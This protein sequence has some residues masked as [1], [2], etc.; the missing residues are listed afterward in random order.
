MKEAQVFEGWFCRRGEEVVGPL[1]RQ[2]LRDLAATGE[3]HPRDTLWQ[4][5]SPHGDLL[6]PVRAASVLRE[7]RLVVLVVGGSRGPAD[8]VRTLVRHWGHDGRLAR[9]GAEAARGVRACDP[10]A[11]LL[12]LDLPGGGGTEL[13]A[14]LRGRG[15][16]RAPVLIALGND[17]TEE[18]RCRAQQA[19]FRYYLPKPP[20]AN[21]L[22]LLLALVA[23]EAVNGK[24]AGSR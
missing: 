5:R 16:G 24:P 4:R 13:A 2:Q 3:L 7:G 9:S 19:G 14:T 6:L 18:G 23:R 1:S 10:D 15:G 20:D 22:A 21:V 12:D 17:D 8:E 11:V